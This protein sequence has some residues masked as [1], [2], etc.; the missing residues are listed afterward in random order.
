[1]TVVVLVGLMGSGKT[2]VGR[3]VADRTGR[4]LVD[5]DEA[6]RQLTGR[7]VRELW[8]EG[9]EAAYRSLESQ[10][11]LDALRSGKDL[12]VAAPGGVVL[13]PDVRRALAGAYVVWLQ[14]SPAALGARVSRDDHRPL[15]GDRPDAVLEEMAADRAD[16]YASVADAT[17]DT[18]NRTPDAVAAIIVDE[19][20]A[21]F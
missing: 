14:A 7:T 2:T 19:L 16:L 3:D 13:D 8:E 12:V 17:I 15:L 11:I 5:A 9:G 20:L 10:V 21:N 1:M 6:I 4:A 18:E